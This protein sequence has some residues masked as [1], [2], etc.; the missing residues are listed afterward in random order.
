MSYPRI[1]INLNKLKENATTILSWAKRNNVSLAYVNKCVNG[2]KK[3]ASEILPLGFSFL[4]DSR[5]ENLKSIKTVVPKLLLRIGSI[6]EANKVV[7]YADYSLQ[8][9]IEVIK[10]LDV[11]AAKLNKVHKIILMIDLGDLREGILFSSRELIDETVK[12]ILTLK[13]ISLEGV[14]TNLTCYGS[15]VPTDE[16]LT[17]LK[18]IKEHIEETFNISLP[19]ISGGNSSSLYLLKEDK[20]PQGINNLRIGEALLIGTDTSTGNKFTELHDDTF[21]LEAEVVEVYEKPSFPIGKRSVD[22][23]GRVQEYEDKGIMRRAIVAV[24]RQDIEES[25]ISLVDKKIE[26]VGA[27]SDHLIINLKKSK[28]YKVGSIIKFKVEYGSLLRAFTSKYISKIY[29]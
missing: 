11:A 12:E 2:D 22:A 23:F 14:G 20:L 19:I 17:V 25:I 18:N 10:A 28:K 5:I 29:H 26:L 8:S 1:V 16:N 13:N 6:K 15:I 3:I 21:I 24:G 7:K 9:S 27:S 4:A